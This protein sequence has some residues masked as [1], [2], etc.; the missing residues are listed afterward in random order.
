MANEPLDELYFQWLYRQVGEDGPND[1]NTHWKLIRQIYRKEFVWFVPNDD[2]RVEDGLE[3]RFEFIDDYGLEEVD[4]AW[5][6][7]GCSMLEM[8][9]ALSRRLS[10][11]AEGEPREWFWHMLENLKIASNNDQF[12]G[13][14]SARRIDEALDNVIYRTYARNGRGGLFPL[15]RPQYDQTEVELWYQLSAYLLERA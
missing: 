4:P 9:I 1:A 2:N 8:L 14:R 12:F 11:E 6:S 15:V 7:V 10:F 13:P 3:L 5:L